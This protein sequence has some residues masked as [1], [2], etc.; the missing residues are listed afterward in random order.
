[1]EVFPNI[2]IISG[3]GRKVGKT[4]LA[5]AILRKV[6]P[7]HDVVAVKVSH[8]GPVDHMGMTLMEHLPGFDLYLQKEENG[9][10]SSRMMIAGASSVY[11]LHCKKEILEQGF[12]NVLERHKKNTLFLFESGGLADLIL[13]G[14]FIMVTDK[15]K[16]LK[17]N[18]PA[19]KP[20]IILDETIN[21]EMFSENIDAIGN[22]WVLK[23]GIS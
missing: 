2:L 7:H 6:T 18:L 20:Q 15:Q 3:T 5:C 8:S 4:S 13:P 10:D 19:L 12:L 22:W 14:L 21:F 1:M 16:P 11:F 17:D 23:P 9:R